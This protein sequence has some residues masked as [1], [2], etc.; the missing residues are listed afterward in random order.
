[1]F[2]GVTA[3]VGLTNLDFIWL[4]RVRP[5]HPQSGAPLHL[6][7]TERRGG[8]LS[9]PVAVVNLEVLAQKLLLPRLIREM[10]SHLVAVLFGLEDGHEVDSR[11][12]LFAGVFAVLFC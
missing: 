6:Q 12:D 5:K 8:R 10:S 7:R 11:P 2:L 9:L 1:M 4:A 3:N